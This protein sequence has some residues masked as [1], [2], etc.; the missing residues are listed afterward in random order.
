M[1][2][3]FITVSKFSTFDKTKT[4]TY[5]KNLRHGVLHNYGCCL[6][7]FEILDFLFRF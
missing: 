3:G 5:I 1:L 4:K 2:R 6:H 7:G